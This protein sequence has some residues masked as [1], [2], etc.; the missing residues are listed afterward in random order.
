MTNHE[1][2]KQ[3]SIEEMAECILDEF[4]IDCADC[5]CRKDYCD[6]RVCIKKYLESEVEE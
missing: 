1:K 3:M 2:I 4:R 6:C 5:E